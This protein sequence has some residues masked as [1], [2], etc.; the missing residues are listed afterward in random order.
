MS[1]RDIQTR[2]RT[3]ANA[4][5]GSLAGFIVASLRKWQWSTVAPANPLQL[6][7]SA[8]TAGANSYIARSGNFLFV[9]SGI[10]DSGLSVFDITN[11]A[12]GPVFSG[13][14]PIR[15]N[16]VTQLTFGYGAVLGT[17]LYLCDTSTNIISVF[18]VSTPSSP[19]VTS[20]NHIAS[21]RNGP[22]G[23]SMVGR[24]SLIYALAV[25]AAGSKITFSVFNS[26]LALQGH[27]DLEAPDLPLGTVGQG[28][29][30]LG[31]ANVVYAVTSSGATPA[32]G[33]GNLYIL[34]V[35]NP[36]APSVTGHIAVAQV[37]T[38]NSNTVLQV[39]GDGFAYVL[40]STFGGGPNQAVKQF[41][42]SNP[43]SPGLANTFPITE[44]WASLGCES[45]MVQSGNIAITSGL[46]PVNLGVYDTSGNFL[47]SA[48]VSSAV[49]P[50][51][52]GNILAAQ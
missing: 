7:Q 46:N 52:S 36:A 16:P 39:P 29:L 24:S 1:I 3:Q 31:G 41:T 33:S 35:T 30:L 14:F 21:I 37:F 9:G 38:G 13:N 18:D 42:V 44:A 17:S 8:F 50:I 19:S 10:A 49:A 15:G 23:V 11:L 48:V 34:N 6:S 43:S 25:N 22:G 12:G 4:P 2:W 26:S 5:G 28:Q 47:G 20:Q 45:L 32:P 27:I 51:V 40:Q